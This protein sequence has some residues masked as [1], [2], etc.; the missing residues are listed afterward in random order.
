MLL[1]LHTRPDLDTRKA[2]SEY[3]L[4]VVP[5]ALFT[6]HGELEI[7]ADVPKMFS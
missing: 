1:A 4:S 6:A 7:Y 2:M 3:E 5:K